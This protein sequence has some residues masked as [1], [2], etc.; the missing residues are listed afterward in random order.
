MATKNKGFTLIELMIVVAIIGILV[1]VVMPAY[2]VYIWESQRTDTQ[3]KMLQMIEL[4][5]RFFID[6]FRYTADITELGYPDDPLVINYNG[7]PAFEITAS[8][9]PNAAPYLD[10]PGLNR[11]FILSATAQGDQTEDGDLLV[12]N[13]GRREHNYAGIVLRD[14]SGNDL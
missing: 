6:N 7:S 1:T 3:G 14:W 8:A 13:R 11:C 12:D 10:N 9:C 2:R 4:Q 5:E